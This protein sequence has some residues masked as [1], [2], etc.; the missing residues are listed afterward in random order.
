MTVT[1]SGRIN[2]RNPSPWTT[3]YT[4]PF[5]VPLS[6]VQLRILVLNEAGE[7]SVDQE[8]AILPRSLVP[9]EPISIPWADTGFVPLEWN[10]DYALEW[11]LTDE[12]GNSSGWG[13][14]TFFN[15]NK[16]P[17]QGS[18][19]SPVE[20]TA[21]TGIPLIS[22]DVFD[23]DDPGGVWFGESDN[24]TYDWKTTF[25]SSAGQTYD[26]R[27]IVIGPDGRVWIAD[28]IRQK[29]M[30]FSSTGAFSSE[31]ASN[32][33]GITGISLDPLV[34]NDL[35]IAYSA[36]IQRLNATTFAQVGTTLSQT[37]FFFPNIAA[38]DGVLY[39]TRSDG[40]VSRI[41][42]TTGGNSIAI[43]G[44]PGSG[45]SQFKNPRG[46]IA[47]K[48]RDFYEGAITEKPV[49]YIADAGNYRVQ[50]KD[51][52]TG[53]FLLEFGEYGALDGQFLYPED[54]AFDPRTQNIWVSDSLRH[55]IQVFSRYGEYLETHKRFGT[56]V[57]QWYWPRGIAIN[58]TGTKLAV[59]G[60]VYNFDSVVK[61][62]SIPALDVLG[63]ASHL[64][65]EIEITSPY[66]DFNGGFDV[67]ATGWVTVN[68]AGW[69]AVYSRTTINP[70][71]GA[72]A[73]LA[74]LTVAPTATVSLNNASRV[75][76]NGPAIPYILPVVPGN[77][78]QAKGWFRRGNS[79][80]VG[81][82]AIRWLYADLTMLSESSRGPTV[83]FTNSY[84]EAH[85]SAIAP[86]GAAYAE[87]MLR[88]TRNYPNAFVNPTEA[89]WD[90]I[91]FDDAPRWLRPGSFGAGTRFTY[92][93]VTN[94]F[95]LV[96][97]YKLRARGKDANNLG[98][99]S[100][101]VSIRKVIGLTAVV[102]SPSPGQ[103]VNTVSPIIV[104]SITA[105]TQWRWKVQI[106]V[107]STGQI[108]YDSD[109]VQEAATRSH[110]V[111]PGYLQDDGQ[112]LAQVWVDTG[113]M[114]VII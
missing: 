19:A 12:Q 6:F 77:V 71:S 105:G 59:G 40:W 15:T 21:F 98:P 5:G 27:Q 45:E 56:A 22:F 100:A 89:R 13:N 42:M 70:R 76:Q 107:A 49:I 90:D 104:W 10:T 113:E 44:T 72:G 109:W 20:S 38:Y 57:D 3:T 31:S 30:I 66:P 17:E 50:C 87:I 95:P 111:P 97:S 83:G 101:P 82:M 84:E 103:V 32:Y 61:Q 36:N 85:V 68:E 46:I 18:V 65:G 79:G 8:G 39:A 25:G 110:L 60:Q 48:W 81:S 16:S 112:Y 75:V 33:T 11:Q 52:L 43:F 73:L 74:T 55:D 51:I 106:L 93:S 96:G 14:R 4:H 9:G 7:Y 86:P 64:A 41:V 37:G 54:V 91:T 88:I 28:I 114:E 94:D 2:T 78:Y 63:P 24:L 34:P 47:A 58:A 102:L 69:T 23:V 35:Y 26:P 29:F 99:W 80:I 108:A 1:P 92:Q 53:A 67:D 62:Y